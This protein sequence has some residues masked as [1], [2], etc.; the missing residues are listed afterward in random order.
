MMKNDV[1]MWR[2]GR[3]N[4]KTMRKQNKRTGRLDK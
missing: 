4:E 3:G 2:S 1:V